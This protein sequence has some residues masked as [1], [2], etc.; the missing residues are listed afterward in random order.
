MTVNRCSLFWAGTQR[1]LIVVYTD[2]SGELIGPIFKGQECREQVAEGLCRS[3]WEL[4]NNSEDRRLHP[5]DGESLRSRMNINTLK[6]NIHPNS[7]RTSI[8][9]TEDSPCPLQ[10]LP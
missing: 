2:V 5:H 8:Y 4:R 7:L 1:M 6:T 10:R 9:L 3:W